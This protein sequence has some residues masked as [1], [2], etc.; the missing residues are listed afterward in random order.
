MDLNVRDA[1]P[2]DAALLVAY[3]SAMAEETEGK[4]LDADR[5]GPGV[6]N[7][8]ADDRR[9]LAEIAYRVGYRNYRDFY[10]NFVKYEN[11]SPSQVQRRLIRSGARS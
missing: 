10:R 8:L 5:I 11:A 9:S 3:N 4:S 7:L 2:E 1:R 6:A